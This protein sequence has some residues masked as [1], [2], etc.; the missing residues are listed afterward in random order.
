MESVII[1]SIIRRDRISVRIV[2]WEIVT[3]ERMVLDVF[4]CNTV[5]VI[6]KGGKGSEGAGEESKLYL[7]I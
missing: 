7:E 5:D 1:Q 2:K 6:A 4:G 3:L